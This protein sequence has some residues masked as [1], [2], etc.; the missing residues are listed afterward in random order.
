MSFTFRPGK[1]ENEHLLIG[2][3]GSSGSGKTLSAMLLAKGLAG[4]KRFAVIDT[5]AGRANH[6]ADAFEFD[7]GDLKPPF[8]PDAYA[9][10]IAAADAEGYPVIV[11]DST[12][13]EH[14]GEGGLLDWHEDELQRMAGDD[15]KKRD[16]MNMAAW[17][18]PKRSH[19]QFMG[20]LLQVRAHL[21]LAFRAE[22]KVDMVKNPQTGKFE[23]VP[24][25]LLSGFV[26]WIPICEKNT[27]YEL[28]MSFVLTADA[29]GVPKPVKLEDQ[30]RPMVPLEQPLNEEVGRALA[31]WAQGS[32]PAQ[33][34][35]ARE[36]LADEGTTVGAG[37]GGQFADETE[38]ALLLD[39][40]AQL[41]GEAHDKA[42]A[43]LASHREKH[44][45][46]VDAGWL[47][48]QVGKVRAKLPAEQETLV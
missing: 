17:V 46:R 27:L 29:P 7:H 2:L 14:A 28:T 34:R 18:R 37:G 25:R 11:V 42:V 6:Y 3:A 9:A 33:G 19:R 48:T 35:P 22:Q 12:S 43:A 39:L 20:R 26:D 45:G 44:G 4:G 41:S 10:A 36:A 16:A 15:W 5:E 21:I 23:I 1:R 30:H 47:A 40:A 8:R 13:H 31:E 24:K 32:A 38:V